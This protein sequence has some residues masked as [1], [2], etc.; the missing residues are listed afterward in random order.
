MK[1]NSDAR[2]GIVSVIPSNSAPYLMAQFAF[3]A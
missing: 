3:A 2:L 1:Q